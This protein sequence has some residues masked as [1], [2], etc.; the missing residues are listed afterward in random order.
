[1]IRLLI[2]RYASWHI[3]GSTVDWPGIQL[4]NRYLH[5][6]VEAAQPFTQVSKDQINGALARLLVLYTKCVTHGDAA[7]AQQQLKLH[8]RENIAWERDTVWRQMIGKERRGETGGDLNAIGATLVDEAEISL[9]DVPTP[10]G[11]FKLTKKKIALSIAV[12]LFALL[13]NV[14]TVEGEEANRCFAI[15]MF[16]T[17]MWATEAIPLFV[18]SLLVPLLLVCLRVIREDGLSGEPPRRLTTP[19][20]TKY[21]FP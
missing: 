9:L 17:V 6:V 10:V 2:A 15:L 18:T 12:G 21:I 5:E 16:S 14:Q 19:Q 8:Q 11:R 20:A 7:L 3:L 4:K 1:M 13:L